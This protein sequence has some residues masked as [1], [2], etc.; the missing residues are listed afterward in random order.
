MNSCKT[1]SMSL[2]IF[3]EISMGNSVKIYDKSI[4]NN[5]NISI[6]L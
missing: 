4:S 1:N 3:S 5:E 6:T 2:W